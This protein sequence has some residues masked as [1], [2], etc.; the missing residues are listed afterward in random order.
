VEAAG[1][2]AAGPHPG[3]GWWLQM[4]VVS[5]DRFV[6]LHYEKSDL[7]AQFWSSAVDE[8]DHPARFFGPPWLIPKPFFFR[9]RGP[10]QPRIGLK[11]AP[12]SSGPW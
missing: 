7:P 4:I 12:W 3:G 11:R 6:L 2:A 5:N 9:F 1:R 10:L 8:G